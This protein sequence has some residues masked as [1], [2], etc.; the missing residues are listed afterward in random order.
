MI[1]L[2]KMQS[3][4]GTKGKETKET[5]SKQLK[6]KILEFVPSKPDLPPPYEINTNL[7]KSQFANEL[8]KSKHI[9]FDLKKQEYMSNSKTN[10]LPTYTNLSPYLLSETLTLSSGK[11]INF[12]KITEDVHIIFDPLTGNLKEIVTI[13]NDD[14]DMDYIPQKFN[15]PIPDLIKWLNKTHIIAKSTK[16]IGTLLAIK[17]EAFT[18]EYPDCISCILFEKVNIKDNFDIKVIVNLKYENTYIKQS[19]LL[20]VI[21]T[22]MN[23][24]WII[25][26][27]GNDI[28]LLY[29]YKLQND[30]LIHKTNKYIS[31]YSYTE[32]IIK[33]YTFICSMWSLYDI[34]PDVIY[35]VLHDEDKKVSIH[36]YII[37]L[38]ENDKPI[39]DLYAVNSQFHSSGKYVSFCANYNISIFSILFELDNNIKQF[40]TGIMALSQLDENKRTFIKL[41]FSNKTVLAKDIS[42]VEAQFMIYDIMGKTEESITKEEKT[43]AQRMFNEKKK[44]LDTQKI[45][46]A[47]KE[48]ERREEEARAIADK[49]LEE[50]EESKKSKIKI[51]TNKEKLRIEKENLEKQK[52]DESDRLE[53]EKIEKERLEKEKLM[54]AELEKERLVKEELEKERIVKEKQKQSE[55]E[56]EEFEKVI[57]VKTRGANK[58]IEK[59]K[60]KKELIKLARIEKIRIEKEIFEKERLEKEILQMKK[61]EKERLEKERIIKERIEKDQLEKERIIKERIE[62]E[63]LEKGRLEKER[64]EKERLEKECLEKECLEKERIEKEQLEKERLEKERIEKEKPI[65]NKKLVL[66]S[67]N[68]KSKIIENILEEKEKENEIK[69]I[70]I[71]SVINKPSYYYSN[72]IEFKNTPQSLYFMFIYYMTMINPTIANE[73]LY[74]QSSEHYNELLFTHRFYVMYVIDVLVIH[75]PSINHLKSIMD[76]QKEKEFPISAIY[77]SYLPLIYSFILNEIGFIYNAFGPDT[78]QIDKLKDYDTLVLKLLDDYNETDNETEFI[79]ELSS[80]I[81][82]NTDGKPISRTKIQSSSIHNLLCHCWDL[83][84]TSAILLYEDNQSPYIMRNPDFTEFLFGQQPIQL[85]FGKN[86][87]NLYN[88]DITMKR[89]SKAISTWY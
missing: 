13:M 37:R 17:S 9:D 27:K 68:N 88:Y 35:L 54:K 89:L 73:M 57:L 29:Y 18:D 14:V 30:I 46:I 64:L 78:N 12:V 26:K 75:S 20:D 76:S 10:T 63:L 62:K 82:Y 6:H 80:L 49:L 44:Y 15:I 22:N 77:G 66:K 53:K 42:I 43:R 65:I 48:L 28:H 36:Q 70:I 24:F 59:E 4:K 34:Y 23:N 39:V 87:S 84:Y 33:D 72:E 51:K 85:L 86:E 5:K 71:P 83:N 8:N 52:K 2:T 50:E 3:F 40:Y 61:L 19:E 11:N 81:G 32:F 45:E 25:I 21:F 47:K 67:R 31:D 55:F 16:N 41:D 60:I 79:R 38:D 1:N 58:R 69:E 74:S 56:K 7:I